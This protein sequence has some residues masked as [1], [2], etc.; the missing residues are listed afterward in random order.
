MLNYLFIHT[1][2][3]FF[4]QSLWRDEAFSYFLAKKNVFEIIAFSAKDFNPPI[5]HLILHFWLKMFGGSEITLRSLSL[6]F[7]WATLY[8]CFLFLQYIFKFSQKKSLVYL[9]L[10]LINP[11]LTYYAYESRSY[12]F[13]AF[14]TTS[15]YYFLYKKDYKKYLITLVLGFYTHYF[16]LFVVISQFLF[17]QLLNK[18]RIQEIVRKIIYKSLFIFS[19]WV[20]FVLLTKDLLSAFWI[21]RTN[22]KTFIM[23]LGI[24]YTGFENNV[25][26]TSL[27]L[28][29]IIAIALVKLIKKEHKYN[30]RL[31]VFL[32][33]WGIG[34]PV[35]VAFI[36]LFKPIFFPRYFIFLSVGLLLLLI[37]GLEQMKPKARNIFLIMLFVIAVYYQ[38]D[39]LEIRK[40]TDFQKVT[41]EITRM[42]KKNDLIFVTSE[43]DFFTAKYYFP[44]KKVYIYNKTYEEIPDFVGKVLI[45]K[46]DIAPSLPFYPNR[47][48]VLKSNGTYNIQALY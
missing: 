16:M 13:F 3:I 29:M 34:I 6:I 42:A 39:S 21:D 7:F 19:P 43:L 44:N 15:S 12:S 2:L 17:N 14:L 32:L 28:I 5:Y 25:T 41:K 10:F 30:N 31:F 33:L 20:I 8:I 9:L 24:V 22:F 18:G 11:F 48:F 46:T 23:L 37:Y 47:A 45:A 35:L 4:T 36:S 40:K 27:F 26:W 38:K 1:P